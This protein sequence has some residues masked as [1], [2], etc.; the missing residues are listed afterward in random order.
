MVNRVI[1]APMAG[2]TD[3][4]FRVLAR[5]A[6][7]GLVCTEM[8]SDQA[9][10]Y[11]NLRTEEILNIKGEEG[12]VSVQI[13]GSNPCY[14]E[15]AAA[16]VSSRGPHFIDI[17]MGC[18]TPKIVKN[19]EGAALMRNPRLALDIVNAV[20][21]V[22]NTPVTV[23]IRIGW[24]QESINVVEMARLLENAG[25]AAISVHGRTREQFYSGKADWEMIKRVKRAVSI[26]IIGNGDIR[27]PE[28]AW[29]MLDKTGCDG[30]M[31]GRAAMGNPW[32]FKAIIEYL[33]NGRIIP[34]PSREERVEMALRHLSLMIQD[35]GSYVGVREMRKHA[36]WY[37]KGLSGA[38]KLRNS[39][40]T[41]DTPEAM[42][43]I[44][45]SLL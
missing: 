43:E 6:G 14:M 2:V 29:E 4:A 36:S 28:D 19:G 7:C 39:L 45:K 37:L 13:F 22:V 23:K 32:I 16:I 30:V 40:N 35:K 21:S 27:S 1:A 3:R 18:P 8:V 9:L 34:Q 20:I 33:D 44:L 11:G 10:I 12:P 31:I 42:A 41:A 17:N 24:D 25:V 26:P 5:E 38:A 15:K